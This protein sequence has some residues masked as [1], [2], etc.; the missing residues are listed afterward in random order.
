MF[1]KNAVGKGKIGAEVKPLNGKKVK[2]HSQIASR[3]CAIGL[4]TCELCILALFSF[5]LL[6]ICSKRS[7]FSYCAGCALHMS[8]VVLGVVDL[9]PL[10]RR[11]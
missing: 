1:Y 4:H 3:K 9:A 11:P 10:A 5:R 6:V 8:A 7:G 2:Y